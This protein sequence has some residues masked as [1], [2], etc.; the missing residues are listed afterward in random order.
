MSGEKLSVLFLC[1][2]NSARS[3][4]AEAILRKEVNAGV[5]ADLQQRAARIERVRSVGARVQAARKA[6]GRVDWQALLVDAPP[7]KPPAP[8]ADNELPWSVEVEQIEGRGL[9]H[10]DEPG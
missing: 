1:T 10:Q 2:G 5:H 8:D 4:F 7:A 3:I 6:D 9:R